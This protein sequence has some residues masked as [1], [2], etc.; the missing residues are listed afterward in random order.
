M[1]DHIKDELA[2]VDKLDTLEELIELAIRIDGRLYKRQL[3]RK[4][5]GGW[6]VEQGRKDVSWKQDYWLQ[7]MELDAMTYKKFSNSTKKMEQHK[8]EKLCYIYRKPGHLV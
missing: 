2:Y 1:K 5:F 7:P 6:Y 8:K 4:G 3:E